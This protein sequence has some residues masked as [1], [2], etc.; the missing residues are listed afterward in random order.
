MSDHLAAAKFFGERLRELGQGHEL[1]QEQAAALCG[2]E[3]KE[4]RGHCAGINTDR[5]ETNT[6][7]QIEV[8]E[9]TVRRSP[10]GKNVFSTAATRE[11]LWQCA[12]KWGCFA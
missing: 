3:Y 2:M 10:A 4:E 1:A 5:E 6:C 7:K 12:R 11:H 9:E 8:N